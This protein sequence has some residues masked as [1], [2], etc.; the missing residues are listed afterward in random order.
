MWLGSIA[1]AIFAASEPLSGSAFQVFAK[2]CPPESAA[3]FGHV[4][5]AGARAKTAALVQRERLIADLR[6]AKIQHKATKEIR[7]ALCSATNEALGA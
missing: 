4:T 1:S 7:K 5:T 6:E 2:I 3:S